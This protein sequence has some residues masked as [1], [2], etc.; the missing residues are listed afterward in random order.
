[1]VGWWGSGL[2]TRRGLRPRWARMMRWVVIIRENL[3]SLTFRV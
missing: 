3:Q 2:T 1:L